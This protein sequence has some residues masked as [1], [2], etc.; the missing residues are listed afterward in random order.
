M[1]EESR[2]RAEWGIILEG[3]K[4]IKWYRRPI[5]RLRMLY[6]RFVVKFKAI[7]LTKEN[8]SKRWLAGK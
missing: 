8:H 5:V 6:W 4:P 3:G 7:T 1:S 2:N